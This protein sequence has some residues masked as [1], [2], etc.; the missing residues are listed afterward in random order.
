MGSDRFRNYVQTDDGSFA[1]F[2][3]NV[4]DIRNV[5]SAAAAERSSNIERRIS[6]RRLRRIGVVEIDDDDDD[7]GGCGF[8]ATS[9]SPPHWVDDA[10]QD[11]DDA[12][13]DIDMATNW[14]C[15]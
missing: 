5:D 2:V 8:G 15:A 14:G 11:D 3:R 7:D 13:D 6:L 10:E 1:V 12:A 4:G 9:S